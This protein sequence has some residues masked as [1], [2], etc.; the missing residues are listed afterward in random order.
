MSMSHGIKPGEVI[1]WE[2]GDCTAVAS[3]I[4]PEFNFS[5]EIYFGGES[6]GL[7]THASITLLNLILTGLLKDKKAKATIDRILYNKTDTV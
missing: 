3:N 6:K 7:S 5:L 4:T 1:L 2:D